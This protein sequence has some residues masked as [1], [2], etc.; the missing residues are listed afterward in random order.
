MFIGTYMFK[1]RIDLITN[2]PI[3]KL[4]IAKYVSYNIEKYEDKKL[5]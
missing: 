4:K 5:N 3:K 1:I 2:V